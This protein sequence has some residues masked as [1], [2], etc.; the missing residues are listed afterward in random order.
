MRFIFTTPDWKVRN[1]GLESLKP[2]E[3]YSAQPPAR[4]A[5]NDL[6][7]AKRRPGRV[8]ERGRAGRAGRKAM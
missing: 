3:N 1:V 4:K 5:G 6:R 2:V 8:I 7:K